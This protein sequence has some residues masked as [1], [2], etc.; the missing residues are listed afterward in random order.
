MTIPNGALSGSFTIQTTNNGIS[1][2]QYL[3]IIGSASGYS[4]LSGSLTVIDFNQITMTAS[5]GTV[6]GTS[7]AVVEGS[8]VTITL[9]SLR[10]ITASD[11]NV[12][13]NIV[14]GAASTNPTIW[15]SPITLSIGTTSASFSQTLSLSNMVGADEI[16]VVNAIDPSGAYTINP[17]TIT[18]QAYPVVVVSNS[19]T[20]C[21][22]TIADL[23][24]VITNYDTNKY[25]YLFYNPSGGI[26]TNLM[27]STS[28]V[29]RVDAINKTSLLTSKIRASI[30]VTISPQINLSIT[31]TAAVI[32]GS[33]S[34]DLKDYIISVTPN[35]D[36]LNYNFSFQDPFGSVLGS[37]VVSSPPGVYKISAINPS[38]GCSSA[39]MPL[40]V[41]SVAIPSFVVNTPVTIYHPFLMD[42][43]DPSV[44]LSASSGID[45]YNYFDN[46]LAPIN[47]TNAQ[48][49]AVA[50]V[51]YIQAV[52]K[53]GCVSGPPQ[54]IQVFF[55]ATPTL[56]MLSS[57][58]TLMEG[59][60]GTF[61][62]SL[63]PAGVTLQKDISFTLAPAVGNVAKA[64]HYTIPT[65]VTLSAGK[66]S[67][68]VPVQASADK[69][70]YNDELLIV[71]ASNTSLGAVTSAL[72]ITDATA[73]DPSN[74]VITIGN[75]TIFQDETIPIRVSLPAGVTSVRDITVTLN[76]STRSTLSNLSSPPSFPPSV[77]I[78]AGTNFGEF[79][80]S[81]SSTSDVPAILIIEG[82]SILRV[83]EGVITILNQ[84]IRAIM[85]ISPNGDD[86]NEFSDIENIE[87]FPDNEVN[88][89][90]RW[91]ILV[92]QAK[93]Y[94][95][96]DMRFLGEYN[97]G[98]SYQLPNGNYF[99]KIKF[100]DHGKGSVVKGFFKVER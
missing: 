80:V 92:Y 84:K 30:I 65:V 28:G 64:P 74:L 83:N 7:I 88:I 4:V 67:T 93:R 72:T 1:L 56:Q 53:E 55:G 99:Y 15:Q 41:T 79:D 26:I 18:L 73:I 69:I 35:I 63:V 45:H 62:L 39:W 37:S 86:I 77:I 12:D 70:L 29:Y 89:Y 85:S 42:L 75:G 6:S 47:L 20:G 81:G 23:R 94:N 49:I 31:N 40:T 16:L 82:V 68:P 59:S 61:T 51:Y 71:Q 90:D 27:V 8:S 24:S 17:V 60:S 78:P 34:I 36:P 52:T 100:F 50:G 13:L 2:N 58:S 91:G 11:G 19:I 95:N 9:T 44:I 33:S 3:N 48:N 38:T 98:R 96:R 21:Y 32:C 54:P 10:Q 57:S 25:A 5:N 14:A 43:T 46:S 87:K 97:Q 76:T 22:G 66:N